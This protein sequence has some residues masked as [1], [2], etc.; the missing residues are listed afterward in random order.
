MI[1][2]ADTSPMNYLVLIDEIDLSPIIFGNVLIPEAVME[3]LQHT[4]HLQKCANGL[5]ISRVG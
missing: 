4:G 1:V 3:E 2:V 5:L